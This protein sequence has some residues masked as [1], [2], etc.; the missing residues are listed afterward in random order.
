[1]T[2]VAYL[3]SLRFA[4]QNQFEGEVGLRGLFRAV[5]QEEC[6]SDDVQV[7]AIHRIPAD[8]GAYQIYEQYTV[9]GDRRHGTGSA[10]SKAFKRVLARLIVPYERV[11]LEPIGV[12]GVDK[13]PDADVTSD[14][15]WRFTIRVSPSD[16]DKIE[17]IQ[18][19]IMHAMESDEFG[20]GEVKTYGTLKVPGDAGR[21]IMY[22]HFTAAGSAAHARGPSLPPVGEKQQQLLV[23]AFE[24][25]QLEPMFALG[26]EHSD[27][28][29]LR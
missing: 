10:V 20:T 11:L 1:V 9:D 28:G 26:V 22:E 21:Y 4:P 25:L 6:G 13:P 16:V 8:V 23:T 2:A 29:A 27:F 24:R 7:F 14:M 18:T 17:T 12:W 3:T 5:A 19:E 15:C